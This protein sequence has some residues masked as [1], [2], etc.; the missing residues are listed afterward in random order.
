MPSRHAAAGSPQKGKFF[1][2]DGTFIE[3]RYPVLALALHVV[4]SQAAQFFINDGGQALNRAL[5]S[6]RP[7]SGSRV[8]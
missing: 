1:F 5:S 2:I 3:H 6:S 8:T 4:V 7:R